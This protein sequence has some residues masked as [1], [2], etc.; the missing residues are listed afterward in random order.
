M[1]TPEY[2]FPDR[3]IESANTASK[4]ELILNNEFVYI[5]A[6]REQIFLKDLER[7]QSLTIICGT[8]PLS[9]RSNKNCAPAQIN[10]DELKFN[11]TRD[12]LRVGQGCR[13][14]FEPF[15]GL[16]NAIR[17]GFSDVQGY[18]D[19]PPKPKRLH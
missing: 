17:K 16:G 2:F 14:V 5:W 8:S 11:L 9:D 6:D 4:G 1:R 19:W 18:L 12:L 15:P 10:L 7:N 3:K 13:E